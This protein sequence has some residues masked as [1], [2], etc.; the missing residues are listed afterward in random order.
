MHLSSFVRRASVLVR[1]PVTARFSRV[2]ADKLA[3]RRLS[4]KSTIIEGVWT[5]LHEEGQLAPEMERVLAT[6]EKCSACTHV[7][8]EEISRLHLGAT[9]AVNSSG[10]KIE[11]NLLD[12]AGSCGRFLMGRSTA[13]EF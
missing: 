3:A 5:K 11:F 9:C 7:A 1:S 12:N 10:M 6:F 4:T 13:S 2:H 8:V